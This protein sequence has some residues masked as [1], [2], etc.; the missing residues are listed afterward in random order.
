MPGKSFVILDNLVRLQ[1]F[2]KK[3]FIWGFGEP[4]SQQE[5]ASPVFRGS[6]EAPKG[7]IDFTQAGNAIDP[8]EPFL[9]GARQGGL[10]CFLEPVDFGK[11][12]TDD[13]RRADTASKKVDSLTETTA[14]NEKE[15]IVEEEGALEKGVLLLKGKVA[16][17]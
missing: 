4:P 17:L 12:G 1:V 7:L 11:G 14:E 9:C 10:A 3:V 2:R 16:R 6:N 5:N 13:N 15:E 8:V